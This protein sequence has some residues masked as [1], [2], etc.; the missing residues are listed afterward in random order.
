[1]PTY[2]Y[3]CTKCARIVEMV[4]TVNGRKK[5]VKCKCGGRAVKSAGLDFKDYRYKK[6]KCWEKPMV[7][8][9][10]GVHP[11][12][13]KE[14]EAQLAASGVSPEGAFNKDGDMVFYS[15]SDRKRKLAAI[16]MHD[17]DGGYGD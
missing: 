8:T 13:I 2:S 7:S 12:Q 15:R 9:A 10:A 6:L 17:R 11:S 3:E 4:F 14:A 16:G 1:M 5:E